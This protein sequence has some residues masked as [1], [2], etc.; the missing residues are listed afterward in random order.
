MRAMAQPR[1]VLLPLAALTLTALMGCSDGSGVTKARPRLTATPLT[2]DF[3]AVRFGDSGSRTVE[4]K[5]TGSAELTVVR[6]RFEGDA[7]SAF[8]VEGVPTKVG[9][10]ASATLSFSYKA[11]SAEGPDAAR[12][13]IESDAEDAPELAITL[14][15]RAQSSCLLGLSSCGPTECFDLRND[16]AHCGSC[17]TSCTAPESCLGGQCACVPKGCAQ[18]AQCGTADDGCGHPIECGACSNGGLCAEG[19]CMPPTC[20]DGIKNGQES[21]T[22]CGGRCLP[23]GESRRCGTGS[24]CDTGLLC[25]GGLCTA[26]SATHACAPG[27]V[28]GADGRCSACST[29]AQCGTDAACVLGSCRHCPEELPFNG[30]GVC[31]GQAVSELGE[32]CANASGCTGTFT[33]NATGNG[34]VCSAP[35]RNA[36]GLCGGPAVVGLGTACVAPGGCTS[37]LACDARGEMAICAEALENACGLC[38]GP[39]VAGVGE[40]CLGAN[41]CS[42]TARCNADGDGTDCTGVPSKNQCDRCGGPDLPLARTACTDAVSGCASRYDCATDGQS[43]SC[44]VVAK[45]ACGLCGGP[46]VIGVGNSCDLTPG[47]ACRGTYACTATGDGLVCQPPAPTGGTH[48]VISQFSAGSSASAT[49]EFVEIHNPTDRDIDISNWR[50]LYRAS[51]GSTW[52]VETTVPAQVTLKRHGWLTFANRAQTAPWGV[53]ADLSF[54][55][56][57]AGAAGQLLLWR[58]ATLPTAADMAALMADPNYVDAL[59]YGALTGTIFREGSVSIATAT[60]KALIRKASASS[61]SAGMDQGGCDALQGN[62]QDTDANAA[63]F[64]LIDHPYPRNAVATPRP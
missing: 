31:G 52:I 21:D 60:D 62:A 36:C 40:A 9:I 38:G 24:D 45:N 12:F 30:C 3:G 8:K 18:V 13:L 50:L 35:A 43:A 48:V 34:T 61:S 5:N 57:L 59:G 41:G 28:C 55:S 23:C 14:S 47:G 39:L 64:V 37:V 1:S 56:A 15:A 17:T 51:G 49:E 22:D 54:S 26:C 53:T 27:L 19:R 20:A 11:P 7:R 32:P 42:G 33:C 25:S 16:S 63:D 58:T 2:V 10:G 29:H 6:S 4:L 46:T 44:T